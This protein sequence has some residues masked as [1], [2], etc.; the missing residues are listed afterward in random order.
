M[1]AKDDRA[2]AS[3][4]AQLKARGVKKTYLGLSKARS[5]RIRGAWRRP[6][7][8]TRTAGPGWRSSPPA[9]TP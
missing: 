8:A 3:L 2:Q 6:S 4:M 1:I 5:W 7:D 9:A